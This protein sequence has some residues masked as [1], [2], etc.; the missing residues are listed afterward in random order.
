M[1]QVKQETNWVLG[2]DIGGT[3]TDLVATTPTGELVSTKTPS[4][5]DQSEGVINGIQKIAELTNQSLEDFLSN[6]SLIVHGTTVATNTLLE[7]SGAKVG[8]LTTEGFRDEIEFRRAYKESVFSVRLPAP[9]QIVPRRYRIGI[10]E[11]LDKAGNIIT[12]LDEEAV[13]TSVRQLV[14][15]DVEAIAV[16]FL[17]SFVNPTHEKRVKEI[18]EE[19]APNVFISLSS[20]VLPQ[21][22]EFE[23]VS[24]TVVNAFTGPRLASYLNH[25]ETKLNEQG[26]QGELFVMQSNGGVQNLEQTA[27]LAAGSLLSGPAGGVTAASFIGE[28]SGHKNLIT[29]DMG[30]TSY[31]V[32]V[33][34]ELLPTITTENWISRYRVALPMMDIHTIGSG[35]G[36]IAWIDNGG[37]L[38]VGPRSAGSY[39]GPACY[40][41]GG[42]EPTV[43]DVNVVLGY[44]NPEN[45]LGGEITL[46]KKKA[47]VAIKTHIAE[48]LGLSVIEAALAI[49][50]IVNSDMSNAIQYV[51]SQRGYD[52][53][54][55]AL[56]AVGGAGAIHAGKQAENLGINTVIVPSLAPVFCALGDVVANLKVTE[57]KTRFESIS[58]VDLEGINQDFEE[59]ELIAREKLGGQNI[60]DHI[61]TRK[62][63]DMRYEGEVHEVSVPVRSRT[64]RI[65]ALNLEATIKDFHELHERLFA[66]KDPS[67]DIEILNLR[68]DLIGVRNKVE[69]KEEEFREENPLQ[70]KAGERDIYFDEESRKTPI[71]NGSLLQPGNLVNGPAIIE[72]WG[73]T[74]VVYPGQ[75]AL[76]DTN[77][78]CVIEVQQRGGFS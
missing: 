30:G 55:F 1:N 66:H 73:T 53:R 4:T 63:I 46:D 31:D 39:P 60:V 9:H 7:Y 74:I 25:L 3:F 40:G 64:K 5:P 76:I 69:L 41:Q 13:R 34:E 10:P 59:M 75:E 8:L 61:E 49:S 22:R 16:C 19:E 36:S 17:F 72:Q 42:T 62:Y 28:K 70:A 14:K 11:R 27:K 44:I 12:P 51:T 68:L 56:F 2:V 29:V 37:A 45:F 26:F 23:R 6:C 50:Q 71:Y 47:E 65:T 78:N 43:T 33:I 35:G 18:I 32:S 77:R 20:E 52:P 54:N 57:L 24:T 67:Q 21:I 38:R 15:E 58:S 48:P